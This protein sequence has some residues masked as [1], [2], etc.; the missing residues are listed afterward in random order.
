MHF[1]ASLSQGCI[2]D[3]NFVEPGVLAKEQMRIIKD[4]EVCTTK[5][6]QLKR[7]QWQQVADKYTPNP[8]RL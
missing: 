2:I 5:C 3:E 7:R 8:L 4:N 6:V 1:V